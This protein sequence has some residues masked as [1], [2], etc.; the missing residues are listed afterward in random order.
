[1]PLRRPLVQA[2]LEEVLRRGR[3]AARLAAAEAADGGAE[4]ARAAALFV[5]EALAHLAGCAL[6]Q[7]H[8]YVQRAQAAAVAEA[9]AARA[10]AHGQPLWR[11]V[12]DLTHSQAAASGGQ[13]P[14]TSSSAAARA[15]TVL[16]TYLTASSA[17]ALRAA[18]A[19]AE[20]LARCLAPVA[21]PGMSAAELGQFASALSDASAGEEGQPALC[22]PLHQCLGLVLAE[23]AARA[24]GAGQPACAGVDARCVKEV[25]AASRARILSPAAKLAAPAGGVPRALA[26]LKAWEGRQHAGP[27]GARA[28]RHAGK[29]H[30]PA[31]REGGAGMELPRRRSASPPGSEEATSLEMEGGGEE[32]EAEVMGRLAQR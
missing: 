13:G 29:A 17:A 1:M 32:G 23:A 18:G 15:A 8:V 4:A 28:P 22:E 3:L 20:C 31:A 12:L 6:N 27:R 2:G 7:P 30:P 25:I 26:V 19:A 9:E 14:A 24:G 5:A 21:V 11:R 10:R 16:P